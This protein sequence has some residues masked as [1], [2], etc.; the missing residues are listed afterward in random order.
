MTSIRSIRKLEIILVGIITLLTVFFASPRFTSQFMNKPPG[1]VFVGMTTYFEDFYY[2]LDQFY[3]GKEG[4]WLTENRFSIEH[5]PP[6]LVYF[7][8]ILFGKIGGVFGLESFQSYNLF[9]LLLKGLF[10]SASYMLI[11]RFFPTSVFRRITTY[12]IFLYSTSFPNISLKYGSLTLNPPVD[13]FRTA[14]RVLARF[15]TSA[16]GMLVN[17]LFVS[18]FLVLLHIFRQEY[19]S[20]VGKKHSGLM[21]F[22]S[23]IHIKEVIVISL[24]F[25][26]IIFGDM[27]V[28]MILLCMCMGLLIIKRVQTASFTRMPTFITIM[29]LFC[30][31]LLSLGGYIVLTINNDP[32]YKNATA[33]DISQYLQTVKSVG[34][35]NLIKGFGLQL[36]FFIYGLYILF[37]K[38]NKTIY[39]LAGVMVV[40]LCWGGYL[41]T[42]LFQI[43]F[44]GFRF[45]FPATYLF[46]SIMVMVAMNTIALKFRSVKV[47]PVLIAMYL[48]INFLSF[49]RGWYEEFKPLKEPDYHFAYI[50]N[51]LYKGLVYLRTAEPKGGNVLASPSTSID[52]MIPGIA[53][54]YTYT[55]HFLTTYDSAKKDELAKKFFNE[56]YDTPDTHEFLKQNNIRF[57]VVTTYT[58]RLSDFKTYYPFLHVVFENPT[59]TIFRYDPI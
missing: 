41:G 18:L 43:P 32:V 1:S 40:T 26:F 35:V 28:T 10:I 6:K 58:G 17:F 24:L 20:I 5:F 8:H 23:A 30:V 46:M 37:Q 7:N 15:G 25:V 55:G 31:L 3:Q 12:L 9:G 39:E 11:F 42:L 53:G 56:W 45:L 49:L 50:P 22:L 2:Y 13:I 57:I 14:N 47:F 16:N 34:L 29:L 52:L 21:S 59:V 4:K 51:D 38:K 44:A 36:P 27:V 33:W 54:R 48:C 19:E